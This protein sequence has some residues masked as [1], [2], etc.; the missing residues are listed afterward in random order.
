MRQGA[1]FTTPMIAFHQSAGHH[2]PGLQAKLRGSMDM[3][4][5]NTNKQTN[6]N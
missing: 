4:T 6:K 3:Q 5:K 1:Y 2:L